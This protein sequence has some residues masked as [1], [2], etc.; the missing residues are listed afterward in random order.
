MHKLVIWV[1]IGSSRLGADA[2]L[3]RYKR[4]ILILSCAAR[5]GWLGPYTVT[6]LVEYLLLNFFTFSTIAVE[7]W[8]GNRAYS[9]CFSLFKGG[10]RGRELGQAALGF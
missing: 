6:I 7:A 4:D 1:L 10:S 2:L 8:E 3:Y 5:E 9:L